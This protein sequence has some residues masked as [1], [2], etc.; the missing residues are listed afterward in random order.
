MKGKRKWLEYCK[1][2]CL[3]GSER[4]ECG[5]KS[6]AECEL[7]EGGEFDEARQAAK[8]RMQRFLRNVIAS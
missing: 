8:L 4:G 7:R 5:C 2:T 3:G 1:L 6:P